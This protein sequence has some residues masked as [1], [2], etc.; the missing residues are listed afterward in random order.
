[1]IV[2]AD[3]GKAC[4]IRIQSASEDQAFTLLFIQMLETGNGDERLVAFFASQSADF[5]E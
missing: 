1:V 5:L 3:I 2:L 4:D